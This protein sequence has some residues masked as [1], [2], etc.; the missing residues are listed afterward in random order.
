[1]RY[2]RPGIVVRASDDKVGLTA[3]SSSGLLYTSALTVA[4]LDGRALGGESLL[5]VLVHVFIIFDRRQGFDSPPDLVG[6]YP[7]IPF[8]HTLSV[9]FTL[10]LFHPTP[11]ESSYRVWIAL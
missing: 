2:C 8:P 10:S 6:S 4:A 1:M 9:F 7:P 3:E 5:P 11:Q